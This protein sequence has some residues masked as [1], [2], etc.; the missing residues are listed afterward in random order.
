MSTTTYV[1]EEKQE[2]ISIIFGCRFC[3]GE[4]FSVAEQLAFLTLDIEVPD[5]KILLAAELNS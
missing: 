1:F 5:L 2:K 4:S 3:L